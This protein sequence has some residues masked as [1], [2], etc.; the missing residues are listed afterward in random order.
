MLACYDGVRPARLPELLQD[1]NPAGQPWR[2]V[3]G[4]WTQ[5]DVKA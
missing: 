4:A 1:K 5:S 2:L 3:D